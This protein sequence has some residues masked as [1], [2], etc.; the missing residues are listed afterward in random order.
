MTTNRA[1]FLA[2]VFDVDAIRYNRYG[3]NRWLIGLLVCLVV[4]LNHPH[5]HT[6]VIPPNIPFDAYRYV[7]VG[8]NNLKS[9]RTYAYLFISYY[10]I[11]FF[12]PIP[13]K[14]VF[15]LLRICFWHFLLNRYTHLSQITT[16]P[17]MV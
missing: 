17:F 13:A 15:Y 2:F 9:T 10:S 3:G 6:R 7:S 4:R 16:T 5:T 8:I 11:D 1:T 14:I 12:L